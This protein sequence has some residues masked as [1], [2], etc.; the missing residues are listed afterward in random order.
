MDMTM[1]EPQN[2]G[3]RWVCPNDRHLALRAKLRTGWS[4]KTGYLDSG[5]NNYSNVGG[6]NRANQSFVLT[7]E[8]RRTIIQV[9]QRAEALD[10]SEQKRIGRLVER[11]EDMKRNVRIITSSR[12]DERRNCGNRC[13]GGTRCVCSCALCGEKFGAV[14][15]A[16]PTFCKDCRKYVCQKCGKEA[17]TPN[18]LAVTSNTEVISTTTC[19]TLANETLPKRTAIQRIVQRSSNNPQ[20]IFLCRICIESREIWKKSGAWFFKGMPKHDLPKKKERD[21]SRAGQRTQ[22]SSCK[23]I[24]ACKSLES[25]EVQDSSSEEEAARRLVGSNNCCSSSSP[26]LQ[27]IQDINGL[28]KQQQITP[29]DTQTASG[30][31]KMV[32]RSN[33]R[34]SPIGHRDESPSTTTMDRLDKSSTFS[35]YSQCSRLSPSTSAATLRNASRTNEKSTCDLRADQRGGDN[36]IDDNASIEEIKLENKGDEQANYLE[37]SRGSVDRCKDSQVQSVRRN[38]P[39]TISPS[40][41]ME[42]ILEEAWMHERNAECEMNASLNRT[43][44][45]QTI[46]TWYVHHSDSPRKQ[47]PNYI[48]MKRSETEESFGTLEISLLYDPV[49]QCLQCKVERAL[50]LKPMDIHDLADPFCKITILPM[51]MGT[52]IKPIRT[53]TVHKTRDPVFNETVNFYVSRDADMK[54]GRAL[55]VMILQDDP[56]GEDF[57][58]EARFPLYELE[59]FQMKHYKIT[60]QNHYPVSHEEE[61]WDL[62]RGNRGQIQLTLSYCTRRRALL[63]IIHQAMNLLPMDNNGFSDPFVKLC[64]VENVIENRQQRGHDPPGRTS[65]KKYPSKKLAA[66]RSSYSTSVK[67]KTLSPEWNEEFV[68]GIRLTDLMKVTLCLSMW[69]KDFGKSNDYLGGLALGCNSKG[70]RL[71]HWIDVIKFPDYRHPAWHNLTEVLM[72]IE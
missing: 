37:D 36:S 71:R 19:N 43:N 21:W 67:W 57:L 35:I 40:T 18:V 60:L 72:P 14:L 62:H 47:T 2:I 33:D 16:T 50:G 25:N 63:V 66:G 34:S 4:V 39:S 38:S 12:S 64:L 48:E 56:W 68:F 27:G 59:P 6:N 9:I 24:S 52:N 29:Y 54:S 32:S 70:A 26:S 46:S 65:T 17:N 61:A 7:E 13:S 58:G 22:N 41:L 55:H 11:L 3:T 28:S 8:E 15:G 20:K 45:Q 10:L 51:G 5:W 44:D 42:R 53:K 69:D 49:A 31:F 1:G 30:S 23:I